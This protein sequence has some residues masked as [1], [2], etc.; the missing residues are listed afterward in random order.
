MPWAALPWLIAFTARSR[1]RRP[2]GGGRRCS[3]SPSLTVGGVNA[4]ALAARR[5][6]PGA[7]GAVGGLGRPG[8][9]G[10]AGRGRRRPAS[11]LLTVGVSLWWIAGLVVQGRYGIPILRYTETYEAVART[12]SPA[13]VL[14]GLGYWFFYGGDKV[15]RWVGPSG[16]TSRSC[17]SSCIGYASRRRRWWRWRPC[18]SATAASSPRCCSSAW[19]CP[20]AAYPYGDGPPSRARVRGVR[21]HARRPG[22]AVDAARRAAR[23]AR[24]RPRPRLRAPA[25]A[26][27]T[28]ARLPALGRRRPGR[29]P[30]SCWPLAMPPAVHRQ[31]STA[32]ASCATASVPAYWQRRHRGPR[33]RRPPDPRL[34][35]A[36]RR[37]R[38]LPVGRHRRPDHARADGPPVRGAASWCRGARRRRPT[39]S[40]P[41]RSACRTASSSRRRWPPFAR[42]ISAGTLNVRSTTCSTS[43]TARRSPRPFWQQM[44]AARRARRRRWPTARPTPNTA[45]AR[46]ADARRDR[47][48]HARPAPPT[49]R[50]SPASTS[51]VRRAIVH[52]ESAPSARLVVA[53]DGDGPGRRW[54][55]PGCLDDAGTVLYSAAL[56]PAQL[57]QALADGADLVR[58]RLQPPP[59]PA[60]GQRA[61][62][63]RLHR[64]A[65][66]RSRSST[67]PPTTA[68]TCSPAPAT[69]PPRSPSSAGVRSVQATSA[70]ATRSPTRPRT[71]PPT[72]WTAIPRRRG[73]T[74]AF[75]RGR[76]RA[77]RGDAGPRRSPPT[78]SRCCSRSPD[79]ATGG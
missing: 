22:A 27:A 7:V 36:R 73:A 5:P 45:I 6:R 54:P 63:R 23:R 47:P 64:A 69:T 28:A 14:R 48:R 76:G 31:A 65:P 60:L 38:Q 29:L 30:S 68:S 2:R 59:G 56:A 55:P 12:S 24:P 52:T 18:G 57:D 66:A 26:R 40:T 78:T 13:E 39:C 10:A 17:G 35:A 75:D 4:T 33:R 67:T 50:R 49:R 51:P 53:G 34:R 19:W 9:D 70:T 42:L 11:A 62:E 15:D 16:R 32:P 43:A 20:S 21:G 79:R 71:A 61:R 44:L 77:A 1:A 72:P 8:D 74:G 3:P 25:A 41:S 58:D 46:A 37:L